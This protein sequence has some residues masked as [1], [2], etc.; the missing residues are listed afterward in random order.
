MPCV[1][2]TEEVGGRELSHAMRLCCFSEKVD[3]SS[4]GKDVSR[5]WFLWAEKSSWSAHSLSFN[6]R[7][8]NPRCAAGGE[9]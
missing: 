5:L 2:I 6:P 9:L 3:T 8:Q 4:S 7:P 1:S